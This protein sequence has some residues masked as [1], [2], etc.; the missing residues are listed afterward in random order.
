[1]S[2]TEIVSVILDGIRIPDAPERTPRQSRPGHPLTGTAMLLRLLR[3]YLARY[4]RPLI[5][6]VAL[7][8]VQTMAR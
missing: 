6:V 2:A 1:M 8:V 3:T 7:Q 4:R 5:A